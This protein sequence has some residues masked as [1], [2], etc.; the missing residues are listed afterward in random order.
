MAKGNIL[1]DSFEQLVELGSTT[2]KKSAQQVAQTINPLKLAQ[3]AFGIE[4]SDQS[5]ESHKSNQ[6]HS[7]ESLK[8]GKDHTPLNFNKL[9]EKFKDKEKMKMEVLRSRLFQIV[10]RD[11]E[12][13]LERKKMEE[14]QKKRQEEFSA[15][16][17]KRKE[18]EKRQSEQQDNI[19]EGKIRRNIFSPKKTAE[20]QH[21]E[22]KPATGKQ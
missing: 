7:S 22:L 21:A 18:K 5:N 14:A 13:T 6:P 10:K 20:R 15:Q 19:P 17:K 3:S 8:K 16:E 9:Q 1:S 12:K 2:A 4:S 11:D